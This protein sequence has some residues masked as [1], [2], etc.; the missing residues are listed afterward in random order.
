MKNKLR[1]NRYYVLAFFLPFIVA[2]VAFAAQGVWPFGDRGMSVIDS[3]HQYVPFF[4]EL[5]YKWRNLDS[6]LY[7]WNGGL[8][9][10]FF[11]VIA[12][13]LSSPLNLLL[14]IFP[15][16]LVMECFTL[17]YLLKLGLA[18]LS[19]GYFIRRRFDC[20][21][22][23][24]TVFGCMYAL[25][26][27]IIGYGWNIMWL[28]CIVLFPLVMLGIY[29]IV[30]QGKGWLYGI[31]LALCIFTNYY[32]A[33]MICIFSCIDFVI[34]LVCRWELDGRSV[35]RSGMKF[36]GYSIIA[37]GFG[38]VMLLPT[39]Y[40]LKS[41]ASGTS[42]FPE[43]IK[44]YQDVFK[45]LSQQF[46]FVEPTDLSGNFNLYCGVSLLI[47]VPMFLI[48][49]NIGIQKRLIKIGVTVFLIVCL[50]TN[51]LTY[52]WHGFH[53]PNGLPGR[54][55]FI[56]IFM[57]LIMGYE[58]FKERKGC[59]N[60]IPS[61]AA[62]CWLVFMAYCCWSGN[63]VLENYTIIV[64]I[65]ILFVYGIIVSLICIDT[66]RW[67]YLQIILL[68]V[69]LVEACGYGIFGLCMNGTVNRED[70][71]S[72]QNSVLALKKQI[73]E[74]EN[75]SFYRVEVEERRGRDDIT[76]HNLPGA[77]LFSSTVNAG[78]NNIVKRLGY[79]AVTNKYSYQGATPETDAFFNI[80]YLISRNQKE[81]IRSFDYMTTEDNRYLYHNNDALGLGFMV[82]EQILAWDY[83]KTNPFE[84]INQMMTAAMGDEV[85]P[86][87]YFGFP[88]P[89]ADGCA[90]TTASW[91]D[92]SYRATDRRDGTVTYTYV[93]DRTQDLYFYFKAAH[94]SKIKVSYG[95]STKS[96]SDE[97][98]H[99]VQVGYVESGDVVTVVFEM[100]SAY[101]SGNIK[102]IAAE[103]DEVL[104]DQVIERLKQTKWMI[105]DKESTYLNGTIYVNEP[106]LM[107]TSVPYEEGWTVVVDGEVIEPQIIANA[108]VG[109]PLSEGEH[110]IEM[111]YIP[112][113]FILGMIITV[114]CA[115]ILTV[116]FC[117]EQEIRIGK[118]LPK[119][120]D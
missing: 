114:I 70:Y 52:I 32:I 31:S 115:V 16:S 59:P 21:D 50:N 86:Y 54:Y 30:N 48:N 108:F 101:D 69:M 104:F 79:Y 105:R 116:A 85:R 67:K 82:S 17:I 66:K 43:T 118:K 38:A 77:S 13:Y 47:L 117:M 107:F 64:N 24:V 55:S 60:W 81:K 102:L 22:F 89:V 100:D 53:F 9:M 8:G 10:N 4:S 75:E 76:W 6:L 14:I 27:F 45:L 106:G 94:C 61:T 49:K 71:Y 34:E 15:K 112:K 57:L 63:A 97:D 18:G 73:E 93:S 26:S 39:L 44:Y 40:A 98:G 110:V 36:A 35:F 33:F 20:Y 58:G 120:M 7:S 56:Y 5:Q 2:V 19:F 72:D 42:S 3:Y 62:G 103:H 12:Y 95:D 91:A 87:T 90:L 80:E 119:K 109:I 84:T 65:V 46:A 51:Y 96:Y 111:S 68:S 28:D 25:S 99:I 92:W 78:V 83:E 23:K 11:A 113:G 1:K 37:G 29:L 88:E 74:K 41:S